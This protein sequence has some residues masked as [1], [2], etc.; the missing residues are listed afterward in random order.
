[1][2]DQT[3]TLVRLG[4]TGLTLADPDQDVRGR[5]VV[6]RNGDEVGACQHLII[7]EQERRV[8][9]LEIGSGGFLGIGKE[10]RLVPVDAVTNVD[11]KIH[12][13][14]DREHVASGPGYDPE[15]TP[16]PLQPDIEDIYGYYG[17]MPHWGPDYTYPGFPFRH[18]QC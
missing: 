11:D 3:A 1:M 18:W 4:D 14:H 12:I 13:D 16:V 2:N 7:D 10:K 5:T 9:F 8:R 15:L 6:D 17:Y